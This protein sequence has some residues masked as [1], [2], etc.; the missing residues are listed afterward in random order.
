[1]KPENSRVLNMLS[2]SACNTVIEC[3]RNGRTHPDEIANDMGLKRQAVDPYL[4]NLYRLG[5]I[6]REAVYP[7]KGKPRIS[8]KIT[9]KGIIL[10]KALE[11]LIARH[12]DE[13][14]HDF[15]HAWEALELELLD[16]NITEEVYRKRLAELKSSY[17]KE[18]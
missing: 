12:R 13:R 16:G 5:I 2:T 3:L 8:Y 18:G 15:R 10:L 9:E 11:D 6:D 4:I 1:M 14:E 7:F 17:L